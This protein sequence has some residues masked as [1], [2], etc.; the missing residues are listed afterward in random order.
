VILLL[1][2]LKLKKLQRLKKK[3]LK[4]L[5]VKTLQRLMKISETIIDTKLNNMIIIIYAQ[6]IEILNLL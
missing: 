6:K 2:K 1:K 3:K 5:K 4:K